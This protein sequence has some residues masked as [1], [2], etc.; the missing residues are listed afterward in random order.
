MV[1]KSRY[2]ELCK[3]QEV[4]KLIFLYLMPMLSKHRTPSEVTSLLRE[5]PLSVYKKQF[6]S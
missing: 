3:Q 1:L 2:K 6:K 4:Q 5:I